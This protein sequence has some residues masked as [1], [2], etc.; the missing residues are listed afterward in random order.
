MFIHR[1]SLNWYNRTAQG[2]L[3]VHGMDTQAL[4]AS[5]PHS[6]SERH[7]P[8]DALVRTSENVPRDIRE[9]F[10]AAGIPRVP[11]AD[12][13]ETADGSSLTRGSGALVQE[14]ATV[15]SG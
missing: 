12:P 13:A 10:S 2:S 14:V 7:H 8:D 11:S 9:K 5:Y 4:G 3:P 15:R 1:A 6:H